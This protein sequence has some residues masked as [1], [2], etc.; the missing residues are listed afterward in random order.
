M[1]KAT[2]L[3]R[4]YT[5]DYT[6]RIQYLSEL[7]YFKDNTVVFKGSSALRN[8]VKTKFKPSFKEGI[9]VINQLGLEYATIIVSNEANSLFLRH[10][11]LN[12][13]GKDLIA[14]AIY[15]DT[16]VK[17]ATLYNGLKELKIC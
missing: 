14:N 4:C 11:R 5:N 17:V 10:L 16:K 13:D 8:A 15:A 2:E 6:N 3:Y 1:S 12:N 7:F 9:D